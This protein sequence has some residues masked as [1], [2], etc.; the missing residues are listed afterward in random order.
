VVKGSV[1]ISL[2]DYHLYGSTW[3]IPDDK[4][5]ITVEATVKPRSLNECTVKTHWVLQ[6]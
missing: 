4:G 5:P 1:T 3:T 6:G 2:T